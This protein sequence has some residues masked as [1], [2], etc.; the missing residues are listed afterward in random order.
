MGQMILMIVLLNLL[1]R[2]LN[3]D[4][5]SIQNRN[6][7]LFFIVLFLIMTNIQ[8]VILSFPIERALFLKEQAGNVY[9]T[10]PYFLSKNL[11][12]MPP[13][14]GAPILFS[15]GIYFSI[16]LNDESGKFPIFLLTLIL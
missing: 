16:G 7:L 8:N 6:G 13:Q 10:F 14:I 12:E 1:Y 9:S 5:E 2:E 4:E 3:D 15:I 11:V